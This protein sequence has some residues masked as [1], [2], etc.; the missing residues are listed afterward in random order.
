MGS[1]K[2]NDAIHRASLTHALRAIRRRRDLPVA[3]V[4]RQMGI[5][6]R[7]YEYLQAGVGGLRLDRIELFA[8]A[9]DSDAAAIVAGMML[10]QPELA[11]RCADSK[12]VSIL[13]R[14]VAQ[15]SLELGDDMFQLTARDCLC[16]VQTAFQTLADT[17]RARRQAAEAFHPAEPARLAPTA[18]P[19]LS[20]AT[21]R[22]TGS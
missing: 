14:A 10:G 13:Q 3:K 2:P 8:E 12:L 7:T 17:A 9:A 19:G 15:L 20:A 1:Q 16:A 22:G 21:N 5:G 6:K 11:I 4:A 18:D